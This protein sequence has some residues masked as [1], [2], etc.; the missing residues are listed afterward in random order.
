MKLTKAIST[1]GEVVMRT[2]WTLRQ[3]ADQNIHSA[4]EV[5]ALP[6]VKVLCSAPMQAILAFYPV[7]R[8]TYQMNHQEILLEIIL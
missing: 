5:L 6:R 7:L 3:A 1:S 2:S 8:M 4:Q